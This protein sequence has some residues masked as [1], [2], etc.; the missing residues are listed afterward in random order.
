TK[1]PLS[2]VPTW[3]SE[4][5]DFSTSVIKDVLQ[6][7]HSDTDSLTPFDS[8]SLVHLESVWSRKFNADAHRP[9][10]NPRPPTPPPPKKTRK[11]PPPK[12]MPRLSRNW[13]YVDIDT[14][15]DFKVVPH[16][17]AIPRLR[18]HWRLTY[19]TIYMPTYIF[20]QGLLDKYITWDMLDRLMAMD[21]DSGSAFFQDF[22]MDVIRKNPS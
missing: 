1:R 21:V 20:K 18:P 9:E 22:V 12:P 10:S 14:L 2:E 13:T 7:L 6:S 8:R 19:F 5:R 17:L 3:I 16:R 4:S 15:P 11:R